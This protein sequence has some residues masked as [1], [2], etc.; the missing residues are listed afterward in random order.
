MNFMNSNANMKQF[1]LLKFINENCNDDHVIS[2]LQS[3]FVETK[4]D[5]SY[6]MITKIR[7]ATC[8]NRPDN[9]VIH[10]MD[11]LN[12]VRRHNLT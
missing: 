3:Y 7:L 11:I 6:F 10:A 2:K 9:G 8:I 5:A 4:I 1:Q 12:N